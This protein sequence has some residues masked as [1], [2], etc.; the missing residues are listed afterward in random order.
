M[1]EEWRAIPG[2]EGHYEV[3]DMGR[4]RSLARI[5]LRG[6]LLQGRILKAS[7]NKVLGYNTVSLHF[8]GA[9]KTHYASELVAA[10]FMSLRP[11]EIADHKDR[12]RGNDRLEN[13][14]PATRTLNNFNQ[15]LSRRN[16]SG[17][18]GAT[19]KRGKWVAQIGSRG[20]FRYLGTFE[21][22]EQAH[23]AYM[24][25]AKNLAGEFACAGGR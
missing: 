1:T 23:A 20:A 25:E 3:S 8:H 22:A 18:K 5:S 13:L 12:D 16:T 21:S 15:G 10:A 17:Y 24:R 14:R 6:H 19:L 4:V 11:G 7:R 2:Y 9:Q